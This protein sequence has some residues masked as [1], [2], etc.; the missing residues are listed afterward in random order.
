MSRKIKILSIMMG[1]KLKFKFNDIYSIFSY[2]LYQNTLT[3]II[4]LLVRNSFYQGYQ[5]KGAKEPL[6]K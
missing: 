1:N 4:I 3:Y 6:S 2:Q 5:N